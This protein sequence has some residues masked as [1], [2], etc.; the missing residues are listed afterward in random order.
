MLSL[1]AI[2]LIWT[3]AVATGPAQAQTGVEYRR[4]AAIV[5]RRS[6]PGL[7]A[8]V[9]KRAALS[10]ISPLFKLAPLAPAAPPNLQWKRRGE[11]FWRP[12]PPGE[13]TLFGALESLSQSLE[14][15]RLLT[16]RGVYRPVLFEYKALRYEK[17]FF[18]VYKGVTLKSFW[19]GRMDLDLFSHRPAQRALFGPGSRY[20]PRHNTRYELQLRWNLGDRP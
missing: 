1:G 20:R 13:V 15:D 7:L 3:A 18:N 4:T 14:R 5:P 11:N 12:I 9:E 17:D 8:P 16:S 2:L 10:K 19:E 6:F